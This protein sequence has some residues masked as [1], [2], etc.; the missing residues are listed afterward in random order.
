MKNT[1]FNAY[2]EML[3]LYI[4]SREAY[5]HIRETSAN[6]AAISDAKALLELNKSNLQIALDLY[7]LSIIKEA[8]NVNT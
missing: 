2:T 7:I 4:D 1:M 3:G 6:G 8:E 5:F